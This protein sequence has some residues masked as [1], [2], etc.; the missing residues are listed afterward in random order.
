MLRFWRGEF[1]RYRDGAYDSVLDDDLRGELTRWVRSEFVRLNHEEMTGWRTSV[2]GEAGKGKPPRVRPVTSRLIGD[3][4][5][6]LRGSCLLPASTD[7]P[8]WIDDATGPDPAGL[9]AVRNGILDLDALAA[10]RSGCLLPPSALFFTPTAAPFN[11]DLHAPQPGEWLKFLRELWPDDPQSI[12]TLQEWFGYLLTADTRQQKILFLLGPR[13]GGKGTIARVLRELI[14]TANVAGPT[15]GSLATNFGLSPL[16]GKSVALVSDARLSGRSDSAVITE[17]LLSISG[18]DALSV[19]RKFRDSL[20]VKLN[21]RFV[22][23]SNELPRLGD[24]SGTLAGRLILL[25]LTRSWYGK[26]DHYLFDQLKGE[27]PGILLWAVEGWRRLRERGR[28]IQPKS[29]AKLVEEMED[30]S[31]PVGAFVRE[32]CWVAPGE[33]VE[34]SE[35]YAAWRAWCDAHGRKE[36]G[37]EETFGR[38]LRAAVPSLDKTRPRTPEGRLHVYTGIRL[39]RDTDPDPDVEPAPG[40]HP[41][42]RGH[43]DQPL[44]VSAEDGVEGARG[45]HAEAERTGLADTMPGRG[46]HGDQGDQLRPRRRFV[47]DDKPHDWRG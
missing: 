29:A 26:E 32:R 20:S 44:Y 10:G 19:D 12:D 38:D 41:G 13:R 2:D 24:A 33:R 21:A 46:D 18:E 5:Q 9:L 14:G 47:N 34:V 39:R 25:R 1:H 3:V 17:R 11:F 35:L 16:L 22:I 37:T 31:S 15:L 7:A 8:A 36:P 27:L 6:A 42:H 28:F 43:S 23:L 30:L 40:G 45:E 4:L